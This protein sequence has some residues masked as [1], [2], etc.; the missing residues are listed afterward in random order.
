[1]NIKI[2]KATVEDADFIASCI[3]K[4]TRNGK[5]N[6]LF[7][8]IF[9]A[10]SDDAV[11]ALL[12]RLV[13]AETKSYCH[14][15]NFTIAE[16]GG[17]IAGALCGYEP[18]VATPESLHKALL[19]I[20]IEEGYEERIAAY[21]LCESDRDNQTWVLDFLVVINGFES[22]AVAKELVQ[23]SLL[24]ARLKGY[25]KA[26]TSVEIGSIEL[27]M[28]YEKFGFKVADE[29]RSDYYKEQFGHAGIKR[30]MLQL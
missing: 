1:M 2:R 15:S 8:L 3:L 21:L 5:K 10:A 24:T 18:R 26:Q 9:D 11:L 7:D 30:L 13:T 28:M 23:K 27:E 16:S 22:A 19:Q 20:G 25:R 12:S 4:S 6:G 17:S 14:F 29:K